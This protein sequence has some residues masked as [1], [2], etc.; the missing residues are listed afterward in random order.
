MA[1]AVEAKKKEK[2]MPGGSK[3]RAL[4]VDDTPAAGMTRDTAVV[5]EEGVY[6]TPGPGDSE[7]TAV[8]VDETPAV[9]MT[10][11]TAVVVDEAPVPGVIRGTQSDA[12]RMFADLDDMIA[13]GQ[14]MAEP[15]VVVD[16]GVRGGSKDDAMVID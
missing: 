16:D 5:A 3:K 8:V 10:R 12:R 7:G 14:L 15:I 6:E 9:G 1:T 2:K 13:A 11:E 4:V